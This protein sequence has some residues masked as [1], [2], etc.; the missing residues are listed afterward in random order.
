MSKEEVYSPTDNTTLVFVTSI[1]EAK[2]NQ[3]I[4]V[5]DILNAFVQ[6]END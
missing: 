2:E 1:I 6:I 4:Q 5:H 3:D